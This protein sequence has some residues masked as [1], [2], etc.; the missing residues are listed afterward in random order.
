MNKAHHINKMKNKNHDYP[1]GFRNTLDRI[2]HSFI[3]KTLKLGVEEMY[4]L[5]NKVKVTQLCP[6]L[7]DPKDCMYSPW[8]S[9]GQNSGVGSLSL[10]HYIIK[11]YIISPQLTVY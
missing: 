7:C 4:L 1:N 3:L 11:A 2:Q 6:T 10:F 9:P 5:Y 8:S